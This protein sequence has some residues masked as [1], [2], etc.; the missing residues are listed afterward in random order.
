MEEKQS[1]GENF[2]KTYIH[3][4]IDFKA[5]PRRIYDILLD[6]RQFATLT[7]MSAEIDPQPGGVFKTFGGLI[8]GRNIELV[9]A[10]RIVQAWRP[11]SWEPGRYTLAHFELKPRANETTV[12]LDHTGF[13]EGDFDHFDEGWHLRYWNP[14][15]RYLA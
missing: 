2:K 8:E 10:V 6:A 13:A 9:P 5:P 12:I 4:E 14:L 15:K 7:G 1:T 11:A 3:Q